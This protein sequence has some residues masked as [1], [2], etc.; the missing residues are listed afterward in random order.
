MLPCAKG[1]FGTF[2][3]K[4][5]VANWNFRSCIWQTVQS[6]QQESLQFWPLFFVLMIV[7]ASWP[8]R[9]DDKQQPENNVTKID[10]P[11]FCVIR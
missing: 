2:Y 1:A 7:K 6:Q 9:I 5:C 3:E 4:R 10:N 8:D 11:T